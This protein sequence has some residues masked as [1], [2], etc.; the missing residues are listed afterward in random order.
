MIIAGILFIHVSQPR[1][2]YGASGMVSGWAYGLAENIHQR[3]LYSSITYI[4]GLPSYNWNTQKDIAV[5]A[6]KGWMESLGHRKNI[7]TASY[8]R[9]GIG[10]AIAENGKIYIT[11]NSC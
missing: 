2:G 6:V 9:T 1:G 4:N 11:Q 7:L 3:W 8:D 5:T 10:V